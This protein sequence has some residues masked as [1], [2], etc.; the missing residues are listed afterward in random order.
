MSSGF[1]RVQDTKIVDANGTPVLLR[2][3]A[4]GG[5][6]KSVVSSCAHFSEP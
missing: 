6:M 1:L 5:W 3:A 4:I 2:G